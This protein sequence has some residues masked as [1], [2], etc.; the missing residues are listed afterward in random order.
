MELITARTGKAHIT[1]MLDAMW[2]RGLAETETCI[3]DH[4]ENFKADIITNNEIRVRSGVGMIQGRFF[5][6]PP[7]TYDSAVIANGTQGQKRIDLIVCRITVSESSN[8]QKAELIVLQGNP[9][10]GT[11]QPPVPVSG[12]LDNGALIVDLPLY[13]VNING[14]TITSATPQFKTGWLLIN[15]TLPIAKGGTGATTAAQARNNLGLGNTSGAL[16]IANGGTGATTAANALANLG[17]AKIKLL[18]E[19]ASPTSAF[20]AQ[21][22]VIDLSQYAL[23]LIITK[24]RDDIII[25]KN[26]EGSIYRNTGL[27]GYAR[28]FN[29]KNA[30]INIGNGQGISYSAPN[31][32]ANN[33]ALVPVLIYGIK[34]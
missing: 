2:H 7:N 14:I 16:P 21:T 19:N 1:P 6:I 27:Y 13:T 25:Q 24:Q 31:W 32:A 20:A 4:F 18:W 26:Q 23:V 9:A 15:G 10:A 29:A 8:T 5:A 30:G 33:A 11:P 28:A 17:G 12:D 22:L 3:F 34:V